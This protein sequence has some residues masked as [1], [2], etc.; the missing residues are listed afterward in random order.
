MLS[1]V[2]GSAH[3]FHHLFP[4]DLGGCLPAEAFSGR[5]VEA[6]TDHLH[7]MI[8]ECRDVALPR[9]PSSGA[10]IGVFD[11]AFLPR[12]GRIAEP[13]LRPDLGLKVRPADEL[14]S[15]IKGDGTTRDVGQVAHSLHDLAHDGFGTLVRVLQQDREPADA[16][17]Q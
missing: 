15:A 13:G 12:T 10:A 14:G 8:S 11:S 6:V 2:G 16:F 5:A 1:R 4:E 7:V 17:D 3:L 9:Q